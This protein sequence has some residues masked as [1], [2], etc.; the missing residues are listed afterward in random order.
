[1]AQQQQQQQ[2]SQESQEPQEEEKGEVAH[3]DAKKGGNA[4]QEEGWQGQLPARERQA[5]LAARAASYSAEW[6]EEVKRYFVELAK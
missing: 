1:M 4:S 3:S 2:Q 5:L 6:E